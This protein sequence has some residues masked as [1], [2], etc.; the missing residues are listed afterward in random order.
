MSNQRDSISPV[1]DHRLFA[2]GVGV[3]VSGNGI[4]GAMCLVG[5][6]WCALGLALGLGAVTLH[7]P[8][9]VR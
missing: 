5:S 2:L 9:E 6:L 8:I 3:G 7:W 1:A 4:A